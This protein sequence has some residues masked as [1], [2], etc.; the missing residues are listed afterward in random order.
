MEW[1]L[2]EAESLE[3]VLVNDRRW[4][5]QNPGVAFDVNKAKAYV[6]SKLEEIGL[7]P[8]DCGKAGLVA[9]ISGKKP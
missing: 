2:Q 3:N 4:L 9:V 1:I 8:V 6:R 7:S 5:H